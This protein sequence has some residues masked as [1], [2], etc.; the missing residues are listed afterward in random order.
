MTERRIFSGSTPQVIIRSG[1]DVTVKGYDSD[2]VLADASGLWGLQLK[3]KKGAIEIQ[4][5]GNGQVLVPFGSR[6]T[7]YAGKSAEIQSIQGS[8]SAVTGL[9][10]TTRDCNVLERAAAGGKIDMDCK[11]IAGRVLKISAGWHLRCWLRDLKNVK[12]QID[13][14]GGKWQAI[15]GD[16]STLIWLKAGGDVSLVSDETAIYQPPD[17]PHGLVE[18]PG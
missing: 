17:G 5:G 11:T 2:R 18:R 8:V 10:L 4:I 16:G 6:V 1:G 7:V 12:Y 3:R 13:D 14:L 9:N 15:F